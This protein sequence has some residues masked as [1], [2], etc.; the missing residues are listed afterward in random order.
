MRILTRLFVVA[1]AFLV[2]PLASGQEVVTTG[3][4]PE[5]R[6]LVDAFTGAVLGNSP[7]EWETM[8][9]E[10]CAPEFLTKN[11]A[12]QRRKLYDTL[13]GAFGGG[14]RGRVMRRGPDAPLELQMI[15]SSGQPAGTIVLELTSGNPPKIA[16]ISVE[17]DAGEKPAAP[18][19]PKPPPI[20]ASMAKPELAAALDQYVRGL[21][22]EG[23]F[24]GAILVARGTDVW[25]E[26][27][28]GFAN[29]GD[30]VANTADTRFNIGSIN[31]AFTHMA[32]EQLVAQKKLARTDT[33]GTLIPDYPQAISRAATI[34][35]LL[36]HTAGISDFFGP[37]F[38]ETAKNRFRSNED[39]FRFVSSLPPT[40][41]PGARNQDRNGCYIVLG[42]IV[43]RIAKVP[44][45]KYV[46]EHVFAPAGM[47]DTGFLQIDAMEPRVAMGY[48]TRGGD[49]VLRSNVLMHGA[50]GSAAGGSYSTVR[51]LLAFAAAQKDGR[52]PGGGMMQIAG[53]APGTNAILQ[54]E[55]VW[56]VVVL[57][58]LDPPFGED[59]GEAV[60]HALTPGPV[61]SRDRQL[62]TAR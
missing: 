40:F 58:N 29:R 19:G 45:E 28:Y 41:A 16:N 38:N 34:D 10:R 8:T 25:F 44:Y 57:T 3:P 35:Q 62:T 4:P 20:A 11:P 9:R 2:A 6:A 5:I 53:G 17:K 24:S 26:G 23:K 1:V 56:T 60:M 55:G 22:E 30:R 31:K 21:S 46:T 59:L 42:A 43:E 36:N 7:D 14:K 39:Y 12:A 50:A 48:T 33:L 32:V 52:L 18:E 37:A 13:H 47:K 51:D 61:A 49:G 27:A 54:G 15:G